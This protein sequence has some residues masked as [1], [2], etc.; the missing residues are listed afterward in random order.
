MKR[1]FCTIEKVI[2]ADINKKDFY[3]LRNTIETHISEEM[4]EKEKV[5]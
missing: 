1:R 2:R 5:D 4:I 3:I